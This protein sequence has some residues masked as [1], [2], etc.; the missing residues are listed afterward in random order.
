MPRRR[1]NAQ[2]IDLN[3]LADMF[4]SEEHIVQVKLQY[5]KDHLKNQMWDL[6]KETNKKIECPI[7]LEEVVCKHCFT[8]QVCGHYGHLCCLMKCKTC[9]VCRH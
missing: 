2:Q 8:I 3:E 6:L 7:C 4:E 5:C 9:P 1:N